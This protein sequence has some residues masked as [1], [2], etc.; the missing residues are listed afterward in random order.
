MGGY[1]PTFDPKEDPLI[2]ESNGA[3]TLPA[4]P[5]RRSY[6]HLSPTHPLY[7]APSSHSIREPT[8]ER[9]KAGDPKDAILGY[10]PKSAQVG[11]LNDYKQR[12]QGRF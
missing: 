3:Q 12:E 9:P 6:T 1:D 10:D 4:G 11:W 2:R 7:G 8:N 5:D